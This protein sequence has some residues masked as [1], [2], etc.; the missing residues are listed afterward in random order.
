MKGGKQMRNTK[1]NGGKYTPLNNS[2]RTADELSTKLPV[3]DLNIAPKK[4]VDSNIRRYKNKTAK[5][6]PMN[7]SPLV[8]GKTAVKNSCFTDDVLY[9]MKKSYNKHHHET[10]ITASGPTKIWIEL[11]DRMSR[12]S[13]EDCWLDVIEDKNERKKLDKYLFS[14]DH[15]KE[16]NDDPDAWLSNYDIK[17]VIEQYE[18]KYPEFVFIGPTPIDFDSKPLDMGGTC[19]WRELCDFSLEKYVNS[20]KTKI[21]VVF[22]LGKHDESG[23]HWVSIFIDL[24]NKF[25]FYF[26]S[27]GETIPKEIRVLKDRIVE[28]GKKLEPPILFDYYENYPLEHQYGNTECGMYSL[29][30]IITMLSNQTIGGKHLNTEDKI[31]YFTK[32]RIPDSHV[33]KYRKKYFN[34]PN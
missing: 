1:K 13:K 30:F 22:N 14:P 7:C 18:A 11:K 28:Q 4:G 24:K 12:C 19:V 23:S 9:R 17:D 3:T 34:E 16:W 31:K 21:A 5:V 32:V 15:P 8:K 20:G 25:I 2:I 6:K 26:D 10:P 27:A 33:F 29:Y